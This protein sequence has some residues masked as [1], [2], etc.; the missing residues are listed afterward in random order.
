MSASRLL[1]AWDPAAA[2][3]PGLLA[4]GYLVAARRARWPRRRTAAF[5][6]GCAFLFVALGSGL[7]RYDDQ[8]LSVHMAQHL[9]LTML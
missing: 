6:V 7:D 3:G 2:L 9:A 8:L 4:L 5:L 1:S